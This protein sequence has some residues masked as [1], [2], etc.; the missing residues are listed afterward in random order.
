MPPL[1]A[2]KVL[3]SIAVSGRARS[4]EVRKLSFA[5]VKKAYLHAPVR[6][7][8]Y[9]QLP[10]EDAAEGMCG[11][12]NVSLY[13][14]RDAARNWEE[15]Y[16]EVMSELGFVVGKSS[17]CLFWNEKRDLRSVIHGDDV[18]T[19][20]DDENLSW[21]EQALGE[22]LEVKVRA[23]LGPEKADAKSVRIL[24]RIVEWRPD[25][26][27][28]EADQRHV[29]EVVKALGLGESKAAVSP[30]VRETEQSAE[31]G[32]KLGASDTR[33]FRGLVAKLNFV[34]QDRP[35][36]QYATK[37]VCREM[38]A[39]TVGGIRRLKRLARYLRGA[40]RMRLWYKRQKEQ[41]VVT[42][43]VDADYGGCVETRR[44]TSG[45]VLKIGHHC[46]KSWSVTQAAVALSTGEAELY[47]V[48][49][50]AGVL[51]GAVSLARDLGLDM[52]GV[53]HTDSSAAKGIASRRGLGKV[54]H[55]DVRNLWI[56]DVV[57]SGRI[58]IVKIPGGE[59]AADVLT[60]HLDGPAISK[61]MKCLGCV[62]EGGRHELAP[63]VK[64]GINPED[65]CS[66]QDV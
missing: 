22:K 16:V 41:I 40:P 53:L 21:F 44:S 59:N 36:I 45:G 39:P 8:K 34:A 11:K 64:S 9:V 50:G 3:F 19:V 62:V 49:K 43:V 55:V 51:M 4:G 63:D 24:N 29:E 61:C 56:Q 57:R 28:Y 1:E 12:L 23:R 2:K 38:S 35:D 47:G 15:K 30:G 25:G 26:I 10:A 18:T 6:G 42:A 58:G 60:K 31:D 33:W 48:V 52:R 27:R 37:E 54:K 13:G 66:K 5:D 32:E 65:P 20:G 14:T 7:D 17:P 46:V